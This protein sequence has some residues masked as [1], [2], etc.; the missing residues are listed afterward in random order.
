LTVIL[1]GGDARFLAP[2]FPEAVLADEFFTLHGI[3][4]AGGF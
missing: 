4:L 2:E 1:T 3:R